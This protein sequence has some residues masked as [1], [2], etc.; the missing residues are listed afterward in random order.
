MVD[1]KSSKAQSPISKAAR[2]QK[3]APIPRSG[4]SQFVAVPRLRDENAD[5]FITALSQARLPGYFFFAVFSGFIFQSARSHAI[6]LKQSVSADC[7][8]R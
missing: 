1:G 8:R 5:S 3:T 4:I 6:R 2:Q 7:S